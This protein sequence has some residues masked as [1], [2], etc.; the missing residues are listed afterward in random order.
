MKYE[1]KLITSS[2]C[3]EYGQEGH[4][5]GPERVKNT[6]E[7]LKSKKFEFITPNPCSEKDIL[8]VHTKNLLKDVREENFMDF[9]TPA[10]PDIIE[11]AM[12]SAGG[13]ILAMELCVNSKKEITEN[14]K[15]FSFS[16]M[17]P[18]GH[19]ACKN[20]L[21][22][23]C[24]FNNIAISVKKCINNYK[25][26]IAIVDIDCHHGNGTQ[27][28]FLG[29][30]NVLFISLHQVP[31]Y[32]GTGLNSVKNCINY[33]LPPGTEESKYLK[34][35]EMA[36]KDIEKF[37]PELIAI[38]AGFD[39]Y[40]KD[41]LTQFNLEINSYKKISKMISSLGI[42]VFAVLEGGYSHDLPECIYSFI[43]GFIT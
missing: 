3:W 8:L 15:I 18:P 7:Y 30:N 32:P 35:L 37:S 29:E 10:I 31:L 43:E 38:S 33:P 36:I 23:F 17:R 28:I 6:V 14:E 1:V 9:D 40:I 4:P 34:T 27:D 11:Y 39:T 24:Y 21:G 13:A 5:E 20:I 12:L 19:H 41:P 42:P 22:G 16:I 26:K 25:K 2:R